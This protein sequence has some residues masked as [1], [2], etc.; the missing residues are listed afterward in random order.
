M[1]GWRGSPD[2]PG[3][4]MALRRGGACEGI[5]QGWSGEFCHPQ[6][7]R[8]SH[9]RGPLRALCLYAEPPDVAGT[10]ERPLTEVAAILARA[11]GHAG[12]DAG[13]HFNTRTALHALN[14]HD[15]HRWQL[16]H[17]VAAEIRELYFLA[18]G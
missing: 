10:P 1:R 5:E 9:G 6:L 16:Q 7:D 12:S 14:I 11:G 17:L 13:Y 15:P 8:P 18:V 3:L 4:M 2:Q